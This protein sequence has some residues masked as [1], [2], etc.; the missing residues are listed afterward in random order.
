MG[1][2]STNL[3]VENLKKNTEY[4]IEIKFVVKKKFIENISGMNSIHFQTLKG[5]KIEIQSEVF[6]TS[7]SQL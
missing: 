7:S 6:S 2:S 4:K 1:F 5:E 3:L